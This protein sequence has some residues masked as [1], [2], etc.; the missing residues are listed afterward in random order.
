MMDL[1]IWNGSFGYLVNVIEFFYKP[2]YEEVLP[3]NWERGKIPSALN[4]ILNFLFKNL[5]L[6]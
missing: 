3:Y 2:H 6:C 1:V 5:L 4:K